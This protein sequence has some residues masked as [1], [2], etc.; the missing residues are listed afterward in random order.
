MQRAWDEQQGVLSF[1]TLA[2]RSWEQVRK[3]RILWIFSSLLP[4]CFITW[5]LWVTGLVITGGNL[6]GNSS[7]RCRD[8][9]GGDGGVEGPCEEDV[10][11]SHSGA[12][13]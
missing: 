10:Q 5:P 11:P 2:G 7:G 9:T 8:S 6:L 13:S 12:V 4:Q 3:G 1:F